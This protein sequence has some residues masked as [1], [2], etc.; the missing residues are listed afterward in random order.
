MANCYF[1][2]GMLAT[3]F[4][5]FVA[6]R[7]AG[8]DARSDGG[9][10]GQEEVTPA[11]PTWRFRRGDLLLE[12]ARVAVTVPPSWTPMEVE[13][14][15]WL[16]LTFKHPSGAS[17]QGVAIRRSPGTSAEATLRA[18]LEDKQKQYENVDDVVFADDRIGSFPARTVAMTVRVAQKAARTK[19]WAL[20]SK[21][22]WLNFVCA[23]PAEVFQAAEAECRLVTQTFRAVLR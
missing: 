5:A 15:P 16:S 19:I 22:Y 7:G 4:C 6:C 14:S 18:I 10:L 20:G 21:A 1:W 11:D 17:L 2:R 3:V 8:K 12:S 23:A 9:S 13:R